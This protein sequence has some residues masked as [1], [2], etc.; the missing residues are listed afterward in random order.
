MRTDKQPVISILIPDGAD[1]ATA[2]VKV[3][4]KRFTLILQFEMGLIEIISG[5]QIV[6]QHGIL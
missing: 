5:I 3:E 4:S 2:M 1:F 6:Q